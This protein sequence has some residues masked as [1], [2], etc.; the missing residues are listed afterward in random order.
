MPA[1]WNRRGIPDRVTFGICWQYDDLTLLDLD[2]YVNHP[3]FRIHAVHYSES[4]GCCWARHRTNRLYDG[5]EYTLQIDAHTRFDPAWDE[6]YITML[7]SLEAPKPVLSTYPPPFEYIDG[8]ESRYR[9]HGMQKLVLNRMRSDLTTVFKS[10]LVE[11][12]SQPAPSAFLGAGQVFTLGSFCREVEY[13]PG[14]YFAGEEISLSARAYTWGYDFFCPNE[15]LIWHYYRHTMP[16]HSIDHRDN[17][18]DQAVSRLRELLV[19]DATRL[20]KYGLGPDR[21]LAD[22]ER[23]AGVDFRRRL[24]RQAEPCRF[25]RSIEVRLPDNE[26]VDDITHWELT[27]M[28]IDSRGMLSRRLAPQDVGAQKVLSIGF[29]DD[30]SDQPVGYE[31]RAFSRSLGGLR[32]LALDLE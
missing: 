6:R 11:D 13:D 32:G 27:L 21:S 17:Q 1:R 19:G 12:D 14:L 25:Q 4:R 3:R 30:L 16:L 8:R 26:G 10:V 7:E 5:E 9:K 31:I 20:G 22:F 15:D 23:Y 28:D 29:D 18:H 2:G 24:E